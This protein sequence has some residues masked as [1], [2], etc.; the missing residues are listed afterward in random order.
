MRSFVKLP[1]VVTKID[2]E[3]PLS[4]LTLNEGK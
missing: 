3:S 1:V 2:A 4:K